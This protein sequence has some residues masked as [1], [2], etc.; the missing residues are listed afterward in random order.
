MSWRVPELDRAA[1]DALAVLTLYVN[2]RPEDI[3][4]AGELLDEL[5]APPDGVERV[6][7]GLVSV[8][9]ALLALLQHHGA[10]SPA[11]GLDHL[12]RIVLEVAEDGCI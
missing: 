12:G 9:A 4:L 3:A 5:T 8:S 11:D 10:V 2:G 6:I 1:A 7:G